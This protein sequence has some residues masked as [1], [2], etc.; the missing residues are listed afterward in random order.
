MLTFL[1]VLACA[2]AGLDMGSTLLPSGG[3]GFKV[4]APHAS[5][6]RVELELKATNSKEILE[7]SR[8]ENDVW[9][10]ESQSATA[11]DDYRYA[12]ESTWNDCFE[13]EG[14]VLYRRDPYARY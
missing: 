3:A 12:V 5:F 7:L 8:G 6:V 2:H 9:Y 13:N 14:A 4:W 1:L 11:G 10:G